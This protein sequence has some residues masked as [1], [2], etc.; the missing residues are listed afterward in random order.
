MKKWKCTIKIH[1]W[2]A[3]S[4]NFRACSTILAK[5]I[6]KLFRI[7]GLKAVA[8]WTLCFAFFIYRKQTRPVPA[9]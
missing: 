8:I 4:I 3:G 1:F 2:S 7:H 5:A 9:G 6:S